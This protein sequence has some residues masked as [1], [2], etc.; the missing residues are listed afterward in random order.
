M[1]SRAYTPSVKKTI[2]SERGDVKHND[3][4]KKNQ[5][6]MLPSMRRLDSEHAW[7]FNRWS[8]LPT[9]LFL[10]SVRNPSVK[11][12]ASWLFFNR[13]LNNRWRPHTIGFDRQTILIGLTDRV[14]AA[15]LTL[16][17]VNML[18]M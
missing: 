3:V 10:P 12:K 13:L 4:L 5:S 7:I 8:C 14:Y 9:I 6:S 16:G 11:F 18:H 1:V 2:V 17:I 15:L